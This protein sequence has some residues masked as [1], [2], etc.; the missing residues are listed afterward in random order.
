[1]LVGALLVAGAAGGGGSELIQAL[2]H[3]IGG[4]P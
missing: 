4:A 2:I 1:M 3:A